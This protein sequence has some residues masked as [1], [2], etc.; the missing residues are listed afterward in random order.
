MRRHDRPPMLSRYTA[1]STRPVLLLLSGFFNRSPISLAHMCRFLAYIG[2]P[3]LPETLVVSPSHSL[4]HQSLHAAEGKTRANADGFGLGWYGERPEPGLYRAASPAW[5]DENLRSICGQVRS[6]LFFAHV[7]SAT[8]TAIAQA[9]CHPFA[10]GRLMFM[11]NGQI[12]GWPL[13]KREIEGTIPD[14]LYKE[15]RGTT[16]SEA[17][18]LAAVA[19][20]LERDPVGA[21]MAT[22]AQ[23]KATMH[24]LRVQAPLRFT[25][26][27]SDGT[28]LWAFRWA[29]DAKAPTLYYRQGS[30]GLVV[31]SEPIDRVYDS[32]QEIPQGWGLIA[33]Q[34]CA[35]QMEPLG[36]QLACAA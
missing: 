36:G 18:F 27:V 21:I 15:R 3:I 13:V 1:V 24:R 31:A 25:A 28:R 9:N 26:A 20:G 4:V 6:R 29:C 12:G 32:W 8:G 23:L 17:V 34:G 14:A 30:H 35:V 5:S 22:L 11:H 33:E 16:D 19:N 10:A 2:E 7:R